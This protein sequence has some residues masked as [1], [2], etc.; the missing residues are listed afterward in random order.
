MTARI[1]TRRPRAAWS[2]PPDSDAEQARAD[3]AVAR[4]VVEAVARRV[5]LRQEG[6][7]SLC[8]AQYALDGALRNLRRIGHGVPQQPTDPPAA[9]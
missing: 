1:P 6:A 4:A 2:S 3:V 5:A 7:A 8:A 9:A